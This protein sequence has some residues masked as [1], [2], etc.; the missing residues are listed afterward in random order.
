MAIR[1]VDDENEQQQYDE[2]KDDRDFD[3]QPGGGGGGMP[4]GMLMQFLP[5]LFGLFRSKKGIL[6][7]GLL[8]GGYF[9]ITKLGVCNAGGSDVNFGRFK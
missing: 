1:M 9:L 5:L 2:R 7:I 4:G 6:I 3:T 8:I